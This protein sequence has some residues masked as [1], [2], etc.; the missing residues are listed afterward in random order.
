LFISILTSDK[1]R[2][3]H[4]VHIMPLAMQNHIHTNAWDLS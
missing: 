2:S 1:E 4:S 3:I